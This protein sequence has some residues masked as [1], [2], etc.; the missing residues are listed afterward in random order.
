MSNTSSN[1]A[2][3]YTRTPIR[4]PHPN[5]V[6]IGRKGIAKNQVGNQR[7]DELA[8]E[9][10]YE[11]RGAFYR[12]QKKLVAEDIIEEIQKLNPPGRFLEAENKTNAVW[13]YYEIE[14]KKTVTKVSQILRAYA[15]TAKDGGDGTEANRPNI[16]E[17]E[18][19]HPVVV[20]SS[21]TDVVPPYE[22]NEQNSG[23]Y[24]SQDK[25]QNKRTHESIDSEASKKAKRET[26][27]VLLSLSYLGKS[28]LAR[29]LFHS[30]LETKGLM[31]SIAALGETEN[32][33][34]QL[35]KIIEKLLTRL[36]ELEEQSQ[37]ARGRIPI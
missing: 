32:D 35:P 10:K 1:N 17:E 20:T 2:I 7:L 34:A 3:G 5:D 28:Y 4:E 18:D 15:K 25:E 14:H 29:P 31:E 26:D 37:L 12:D 13:Y 19:I 9:K 36:E 22:T 8:Q 30:G 6:I 24:M 23:S 27:Q 21:S 11:Y 33:M 16:Q